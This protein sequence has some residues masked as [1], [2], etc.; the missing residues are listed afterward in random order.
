MAILPPAPIPIA[1]VYIDES[2]QQ[3]Q[4]LVLGAIVLPIDNRP[5]YLKRL[6]QARVPD[7]PRDEMKWTKASRFKLDAY[8]R[9]VDS[10]FDMPEST[11]DFHSIV[12]DTSKQKHAIF[13]QGDRDIGFNKEIYQLAMKCGRLYRNI[14]HVYPDYRTTNQKPEELRLILNRGMQKKSDKRDWPYRRLQFRDSKK[15]ELLQLADICAGA[16]AY[17]LNGHHLANNASPAKLALCSHILQRAG[18]KD[19]TRSTL[20]RGKFTIWHR[21]SR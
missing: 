12:I 21:Q 4:Y 19:V 7:L 17:R 15:T 8:K 6:W 9:V 16:I 2:S 5:R 13:N 11:I 14:F 1:E 3:H 20:T 18:I 10:F